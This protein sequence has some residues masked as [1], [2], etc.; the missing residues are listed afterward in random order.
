MASKKGSLKMW[1]SADS[2][3]CRPPLSEQPQH[4]DQK[5]ACY[6]GR[7]DKGPLL[8]LTPGLVARLCV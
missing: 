1:I 6:S 2:L 7:S 8:H 3:G 5:L 4:Q